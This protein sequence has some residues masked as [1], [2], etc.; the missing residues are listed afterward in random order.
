MSPLSP[1]VGQR[2]PFMAAAAVWFLATSLLT[3]INHAALSHL[4]QQARHSAPTTQV[5]ALATQVATLARQIEAIQR[6]PRPISPAEWT[7][8]RQALDA[9]LTAVAQAQA[10]LASASDLK[11]LQTRMDTLE[12]RLT[13]L[14]DTVVARV[15]RPAAKAAVPAPPVPPFHILGTE[16]R[17]GV[18]FLSITPPTAT[19]LA[20]LR[21][22]RPGDTKDGWQLQAID[23]HEAVFQVAGQTQRVAMP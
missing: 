2:R 3:L 22:L 9:R 1:S 8:A 6:Q 10:D 17:G 23:A 15:R 20:D 19:S 7:Q 14:H 18:V 4:T 12:A 5:N 16:W 13:T 21:L 11:A